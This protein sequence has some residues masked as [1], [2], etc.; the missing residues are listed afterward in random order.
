MAV[1]QEGVLMPDL[2]VI[3]KLTEMH[4]PGTRPTVESEHQK[5]VNNLGRCRI[6]CEVF[7]T[8]LECAEDGHERWFEI[9]L[10]LEVGEHRPHDHPKNQKASL[11]LLGLADHLVQRVKSHA[12]F[13]LDMPAAY[14]TLHPSSPEH[15]IPQPRMA[16]SLSLVFRGLEPYSCRNE[17]ALLTQLRKELELLGT[18]I[19][20]FLGDGS[21]N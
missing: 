10:H 12:P 15:G 14:Y 5:L 6:F 9:A 18:P 1:S 20:T 8:L 4:Y 7:P 11:L 17:P 2:K 3:S 19:A 21:L 16:L 13:A